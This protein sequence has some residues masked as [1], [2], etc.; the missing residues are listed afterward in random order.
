MVR[1]LRGALALATVCTT[2]A[3]NKSSADSTP[4]PPSGTLP[5]FGHAVIV[6]EENHDYAQAI[7]SIEMPYL[8]SLIA[9]GG[10]ATE[11]YANTHPSIGNYFML[12]TGQIITNSDGYSRTISEDNIVRQL[13]AAGKTWKAYA[14]D[15]PA[16]G[17]TGQTSGDYA[18]K[19]NPLSFF[20]DV[21]DDSAQR[22]RLVPFTQF[23]TD[24]AGDSLPDYSFV[25]P[26]LCNDAH[27]CSL[28]TADGWLQTHIAPL[29]ASAT[30]Q[31]DGLLIIVFDEADS[32]DTHGG[33]R[34]V[35]VVVSPMAKPG[36]RSTGL[37]Q[38]ESTLRLMAEGLGLTVFPGAAATAPNM[39]EFF[40]PVVATEVD[41]I[42]RPATLAS[43]RY[44][45]PRSPRP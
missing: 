38:H 17:F 8:H 37:Y 14:E 18:R 42:S 33:G 10:L 30:F 7:D 43:T 25:V 35:W 29:I 15:L 23:A 39:S 13:L 16:V 1:P 24:L 32:D 6:V 31:T 45:D 5:R 19:H 27:D 26:N 22:Q 12:T 4:P 21:V 28:Q 34:I 40:T 36:Y 20:S 3:C 41:R 44:R 9:Q 2:I 11:Y